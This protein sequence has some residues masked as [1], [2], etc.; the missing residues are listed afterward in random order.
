MANAPI[1]ALNLSLL[2]LRPGDNDDPDIR[3]MPTIL[4]ALAIF[5]A[6]AWLFGRV[7][8]KAETK[9]SGQRGQLVYYAMFFGSVLVAYCATK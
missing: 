4:L 9:K 2:Q 3:L 6:A 8:N 7:A 5:A 1:S